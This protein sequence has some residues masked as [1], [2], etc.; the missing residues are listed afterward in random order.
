MRPLTNTKNLGNFLPT[1]EKLTS[2]SEYIYLAGFFK[3]MSKK[4]GIMSCLKICLT[5]GCLDIAIFLKILE[6]VTLN[7]SVTAILKENHS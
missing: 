7:S 5:I 4:L 3:K 1:K 2:K 6:S